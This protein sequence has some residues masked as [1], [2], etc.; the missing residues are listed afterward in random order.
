MRLDAYTGEEASED[1]NYQEFRRSFVADVANVVFSEVVIPLVTKVVIHKTGDIEFDIDLPDQERTDLPVYFREEHRLRWLIQNIEWN[2][3]AHH[4][5]YPEEETVVERVIE[6]GETS[7]AC[8]D[9]EEVVRICNSL[10]RWLPMVQPGARYFRGDADAVAAYQEWYDG[11]PQKFKDDFDA[12]QER[13]RA[14]QS[15]ALG[16][17]GTDDHTREAVRRLEDEESEV[18]ARLGR[19]QDQLQ[20]LSRRLA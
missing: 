20:T 3:K 4:S 6:E 19:I 8:D 9:K 15:V 13:W 12:E 11:L 7:L 17:Y 14:V 16:A 18:L 10:E 2:I 1:P 5:L